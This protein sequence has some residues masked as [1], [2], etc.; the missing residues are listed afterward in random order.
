MALFQNLNSKKLAIVFFCILLAALFIIFAKNAY[1]VPAG[2]SQFFLVPA[3]QFAKNGLLIS[4]LF[5]D[6]KTIDLIIDPTGMRRFLFEPP[7]FPLILSQ[8]MLAP[9]SYGI[10]FA[11]GFINIAL[12]FLSAFLFYKFAVKNRELKWSSVFLI[13]ISL[14]ALTSSLAETGRPETLARLFIVLALLASF[15][16]LKKYDWIFYGIFLGLIFATHPALGFISIL[17][18][19]I[20]FGATLKFKEIILKG[21][22]LILIAFFTVLGA[23]SLGPFSIKETIEGTWANAITVS[24]ALSTSNHE[25][26]EFRNLIKYYFTSQAAPFYGLV[27]ILTIIAGLFFFFKYR[28]KIVSLRATVFFGVALIAVFIKLIFSAGHIF[29]ITAFA[30]VIFLV[31]F[32]FFLKTGSLG[33]ISTVL[34]LILVSI[35]IIR[36]TLLFPSFLKQRPTLKQAR[37]DYAKI[38]SGRPNSLVGI[39]GSLWPLTE[40]YKNVYSYN[41]WPEKPKTDTD[42]V[43]FG[44][45]YSGLL[46]P[47][48]IK[49]CEIIDD[50]FSKEAPKFLGFKLGNT[51][52]GYGYAVYN[53]N[54]DES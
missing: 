51:M 12:L 6:E 27:I 26:L 49:G 52:P 8:L 44:Q 50:K 10:F 3:I 48:K 53:C 5:P 46:K 54:K 37:V 41:S 17:V 22:A 42:L 1:P 34:V 7:L 19:G 21:S 32:Y 35:G 29:Y 25:F 9:A 28:Q 24:H 4:P 38:V 39:T 40:N 16:I 14:L 31:L 13:F 15:F 30:P 33:K 18:L 43:F 36:T 23:I 47:P 11:L 2:D 45:R 20:F